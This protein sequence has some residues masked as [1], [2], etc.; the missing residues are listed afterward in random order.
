MVTEKLVKRVDALENIAK[1]QGITDKYNAVQKLRN[2][3]PSLATYVSFWWLWVEQLLLGFGVD[4][5]TYDWLSG[6]L[7]PVVYWHYHRYKTKNPNQRNNYA[8]VARITACIR[9][10]PAC[11]FRGGLGLERI[12]RRQLTRNK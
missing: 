2:Q 1:E 5:P 4:Q 3:I 9:R 12:S 7:L 8:A 11:F 6:E 10:P